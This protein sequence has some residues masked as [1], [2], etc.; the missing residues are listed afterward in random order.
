MCT[1]HTCT[2]MRVCAWVCLFTKCKHL[3]PAQTSLEILNEEHLKQRGDFSLPTVY[4]LFL[5]ACLFLAEEPTVPRIQ[6]V[7][8]MEPI[9]LFGNSLTQTAHWWTET[10]LKPKVLGSR[11]VM[12][13]LVIFNKSNTAGQKIWTVLCSLEG[14][15][16]SNLFHINKK[17][18]KDLLHF[19]WRIILL[20]FSWRWS[21]F[22]T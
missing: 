8:R 3:Q 22:K 19:Y 9:N 12:G 15:F 13:R 1:C 5:V 17:E 16:G 21:Q 11:T 10:A 18:R 14:R 7:F 20:G 6:Q 4:L 2:S